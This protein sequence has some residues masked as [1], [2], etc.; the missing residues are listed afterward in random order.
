MSRPCYLSARADPPA[1][2]DDGRTQLLLCL[3]GLLP[4]VFRGASYN[5]PVALWIP[6]EYPRDVP[7]VYVVPTQDMLVKSGRH[8]D[9]SGRTTIDYISHWHR[10]DEVGLPQIA[11]YRNSFRV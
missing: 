8:V 4:I 7:L 11:P 1:A 10:K 5:I 3:H 6:R 2:F 9:P